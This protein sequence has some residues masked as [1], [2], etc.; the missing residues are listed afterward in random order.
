MFGRYASVSHLPAGLCNF[1]A[2]A[3][4]I[5][6]ILKVAF[7]GGTRFWAIQVFRGRS[8]RWSIS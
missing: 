1:Q 3:P 2:A 6:L 5:L 7:I 8:E 4:G